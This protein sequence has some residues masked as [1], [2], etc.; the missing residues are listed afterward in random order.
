MLAGAAVLLVASVLAGESFV[1]PQ[2]IETRAALAC[3]IVAGSIAVFLL[4]VFV[5]QRWTAS[6]AAYV[7]VDIPVVTV[8][9]SAWLD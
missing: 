1:L 5:I 7:M 9:L 3:V 2:R 6:R 4:L 8:L